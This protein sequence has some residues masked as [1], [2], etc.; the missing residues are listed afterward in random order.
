M[1]ELQQAGMS[2]SDLYSR[3]GKDVL[4]AQVLK[5]RSDIGEIEAKQGE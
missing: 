5:A 3:F 4:K 2:M 1:E